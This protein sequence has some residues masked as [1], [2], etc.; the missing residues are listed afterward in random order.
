MKALTLS[1]WTEQA[2][3]EP[4]P[5]LPPDPSNLWHQAFYVE[6]LRHASTRGAPWVLQYEQALGL[7]PTQEKPMLNPEDTVC[8]PAEPQSDSV[9][10]R[11]PDHTPLLGIPPIRSH[12]M[13]APGVH[14]N[15]TCKPPSL[16]V[17]F[18]QK[19]FFGFRW[20]KV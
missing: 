19:W 6:S 16:W 12:L 10:F 13:L 11:E 2:R 15:L 7:Q 4:I 9:R 20:E 14:L 5:P 8:A 1:Q 18:W 3:T 17:Q